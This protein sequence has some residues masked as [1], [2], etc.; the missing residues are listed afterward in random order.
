M[1]PSNPGNEAVSRGEPSVRSVIKSLAGAGVVGL[2]LSSAARASNILVTSDITV[3]TTWTASNTYDLQGQIFVRPG[4]TLTI[5]AG[6]VVA[7]DTGI[8]GSLAVCRGAQIFVNGT[9]QN[10][11][12]MTSTADVATWSGGNP[13]TGVWRAVCNEWG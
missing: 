2:A 8:G 13:K 6:T 4:A 10:P 11:V 12:I 9:Q 3:S 7:S 1:S 5:N